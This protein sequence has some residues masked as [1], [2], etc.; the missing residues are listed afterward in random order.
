MSRGYDAEGVASG[1]TTLID[2][3]RLV[4]VLHDQGTAHR[5]ATVST[6]NSVQDRADRPRRLAPTN[7]LLTPAGDPPPPRAH[8]RVDDLRDV[9]TGADVERGHV[10]AGFAGA[11][12]PDGTA[13]HPVHGALSIDLNRF[14]DDVEAVAGP[15]RFL[16]GR[17]GFA[18]VTLYTRRTGA[19]RVRWTDQK[20]TQR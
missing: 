20:G 16:L 9:A 11:W 10:H 14:L 4:G 17:A 15:H 6:G 1:R 8:L 13:H 3:G 18:A 12:S 7:L 19:V 5:A 2:R